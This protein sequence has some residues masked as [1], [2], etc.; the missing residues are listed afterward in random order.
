MATLGCVFIQIKEDDKGLVSRCIH[1]S[2]RV[3]S[4]WKLRPNSR[5]S[6]NDALPLDA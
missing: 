2:R 1:A 5:A 6:E 3:D 4:F